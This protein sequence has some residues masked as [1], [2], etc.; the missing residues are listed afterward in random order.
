MLLEID[1]SDDDPIFAAEMLRRIV[2]GMA[3]ASIPLFR[4]P[5]SLPR[6]EDSGIYFR[7]EPSHGSG[8][9]RFRMPDFTYARGWGDCDGLVIYRLGELMAQGIRARST[10]ADWSGVGAMHAQIRLP[11][12]RIEDPSLKLGAVNQWPDDFTFDR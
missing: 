5:D 6:L 2:D 10:I 12:G 9:E 8:V 11:N 1:I 3:M 4:G 7:E